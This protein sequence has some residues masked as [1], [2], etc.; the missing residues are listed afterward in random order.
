MPYYAGLKQIKDA[1]QRP[2]T[3]DGLRRLLDVNVIGTWWGIKKVIAPMRANGG[4]SIV[5]LS[6]VAGTHGIPEHGSYGASKWAV[7]GLTK[8]AA[9][10]LGR[11]NIRVNSVHPGGIAGT[12]MF[13]D[14]SSEAEEKERRARV[15]LHRPGEVE[16]VSGLVIFLASDIR[17]IEGVAAFGG[18]DKQITRKVANAMRQVYL[19]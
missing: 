11:D 15:P 2:R 8:V 18:T 14:P 16:E 13:T 6:S 7:R 4:G 1:K 3:I 5:N 10:E 12:G 9:A 17:R 19:G